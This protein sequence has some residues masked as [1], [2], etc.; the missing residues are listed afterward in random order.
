M[1]IAEGG[2]QPIIAGAP[3]GH[4][5]LDDAVGV[6][7][8]EDGSINGR[9]FSVLQGDEADLSPFIPAD[10][11]IGSGVLVEENVPAEGG[12]VLKMI[13]GKVVAKVVVMGKF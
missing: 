2:L 11:A 9:K 10:F 8:P 12:F 5:V 13:N 3:V 4:K 1:A 7:G 6:I